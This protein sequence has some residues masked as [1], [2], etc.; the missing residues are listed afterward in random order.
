M[1][2]IINFC[3]CLFSGLLLWHN[4]YRL[5]KDKKV[6]GV[7]L[8]FMTFYM[9]WGFW[10]FYYYPSLGQ[11]FSLIGTIFGATASAV[12]VVMAVYYKR[13]NIVKTKDKKGGHY[14]SF[15]PML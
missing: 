4:C 11:W 13:K 6:Q 15:G 2:D 1:I 10:N 9:V 3:F 12:W 5:Y 8:S 14:G 7:S